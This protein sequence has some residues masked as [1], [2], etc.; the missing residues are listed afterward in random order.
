LVVA[1]AQAFVS[2]VS[3]QLPAFEN[4][5]YGLLLYGLAS[6]AQPLH[7]KLLARFCREAQRKLSGLSG[8]GLGLL[9][10]GLAQYGFDE[11]PDAQSWWSDVFAECSVKWST[12]GL[13]GC[14]LAALGLAQLGPRYLPP[15]DWESD[16]VARYRVLVSAKPASWEELVVGFRAAAGLEPSEVL[17]DCPWLCGLL[18]QV[19]KSW[20][21]RLSEGQQGAGVLAIAAVIDGVNVRMAATAAFLSQAAEVGVGDSSAGVGAAVDGSGLGEGLPYRD[22]EPTSATA[23]LL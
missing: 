19:G 18:L 10:W 8:E 6:L 1:V 23:V 3:Q 9:V 11:M 12:A 2:Q 14:A 21:L 4:E 17:P 15:G 13:R 5:D 16:W 20:G 22:V 7:P